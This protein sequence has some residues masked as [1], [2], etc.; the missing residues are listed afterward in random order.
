MV[1]RVTAYRS[2]AGFGFITPSH[3]CGDVFV[4]A[5]DIQG[6]EHDLE[7]GDVVEFD[8]E[9]GSDGQLRAVHVRPAAP[10]A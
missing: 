5:G 3:G 10:G 7:P 2:P 8:P 9:V 1:G 4:Q 6:A